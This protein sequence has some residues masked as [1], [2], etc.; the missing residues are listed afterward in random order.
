MRG[1]ITNRLERSRQR[2]AETIMRTRYSV[3]SARSIW[4]LNGVTHWAGDRDKREVKP[5][6]TPDQAAHCTP[7]HILIVEDNKLSL[8]LLKDLLEVHGYN[9][10]GTALGA[11]AVELA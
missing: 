4:P 5:V 11:T 2:G 6:T 8:R 9:V 1:V 10:V 7:K 3:K